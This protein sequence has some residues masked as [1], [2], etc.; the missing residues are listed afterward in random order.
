MATFKKI[1]DVETEAERKKRERI[2]AKI[3][4]DPKGPYQAEMNKH[5]QKTGKTRGGL[6][7]KSKSIAP[8]F[9]TTYYKDSA[10][11]GQFKQWSI[12]QE[13]CDVITEWGRT[14]STLLTNRNTHASVAAAER[15]MK[16]IMRTK[17]LEGYRNQP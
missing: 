1:H 6:P 7:P 3:T 9:S 11:K 12:W 8:P 10:V 14:G 5:V 2:A 17:R 13:G 16:K 15:A 4:K